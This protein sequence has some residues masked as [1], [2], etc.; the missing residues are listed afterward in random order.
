MT[1]TLTATKR[2]GNPAAIR[3]QELVPAVYYGAGKDAVS[4]TV[5]LKEFAKALKEAGETTT[6]EL[7]LGGEKINTLIHDIQ[8]DPLTGLPIHVDF[9]VVDMNKEIEVAVPIEFTGLAEAEKGGLGTIVKVLHEVQVKA[10]PANL[11]HSIAVDV[12]P[13]ATLEDQIKAKDLALG[14]NVEL[15]TNPDEV[16]ALVAPFVEEKEEASAPIDLSS[17]EV[18]KKGK[19]EEPAEPAE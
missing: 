14:A 16:V 3:A 10:L 19:E 15:I 9:L 8:R 13:L 4:I 6:I 18:E 17:I 5:P 2:E 12:T 7:K 1:V 11:P